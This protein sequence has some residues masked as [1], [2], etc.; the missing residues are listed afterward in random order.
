MTFTAAEVATIITATAT[1]AVCVVLTLVV[2]VIDAW[3]IRRMRQAILQIPRQDP[4]EDPL[5]PDI[6]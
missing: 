6:E 5:D 2:F 3:A 1:I 4:R